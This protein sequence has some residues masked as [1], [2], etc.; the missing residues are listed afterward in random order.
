MLKIRKLCRG[1]VAGA[2]VLTLTACDD[3]LTVQDPSRFT[4]ED[5][6]LALTAVAAGIEG[7]LHGAL[8]TYIIQTALL[9]DVFQH[10]GTWIGYDDTDHGRTDY[11]TNRYSGS[12]W[13]QLRFEANDAIARFDRVEADGGAVPTALRAQVLVTE[14]WLDLLSAMGQCEAPQGQGTAAITD[15]Q[16][17]AQARDK[18][19]AVL[20]IAT[21]DF[22]I[23]ANAGIARAELMLGNYGP[24][25]ADAAA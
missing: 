7:R 18:L 17:F 3:L 16:M 15:Q 5:V 12:F 11:E 13:L 20:G 14:G 25:A 10:T 19:T 4:D 24:A 6:D 1:L 23:W 9:S 21:G 22:T 2:V 8:D